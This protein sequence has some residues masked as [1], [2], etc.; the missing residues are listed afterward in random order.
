MKSPKLKDVE[1][2]ASFE[3]HF[4]TWLEGAQRIC[5]EN[6]QRRYVGDFP[7]LDQPILTAKKGSRYIKI[8][9]SDPHSAV[10]AFVDRKN[11][12]ILKPASWKAPA[13]HAR[14]NIFDNDNGL[15]SMG[16]YGP[17]YLR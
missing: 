11:G 17:A 16:E 10:H 12:D 3:K 8:I 9:R 4:E 1:A 6:H 5:N 7:T 2:E 15:A 14:G 13:K